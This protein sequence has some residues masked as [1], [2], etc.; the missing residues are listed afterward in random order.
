[1]KKLETKYNKLCISIL[2]FYREIGVDLS[3]FQ[4]MEK[5]NKSMP[6]KLLVTGG[7][8]L[9]EYTFETMVDEMIDYWFKIL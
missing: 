7:K 1:M 5:Q 8:G 6:S 4:N 2:S 9:V 3:V